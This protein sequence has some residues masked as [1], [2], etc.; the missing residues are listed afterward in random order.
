VSHTL[1]SVDDH[2]VEPPHLWTSRLPRRYLDVGPRVEEE[3]GKEFWVYED[4]RS[5]TVGLNAVVGKDPSEWNLDPLRFDD[6]LPGCYDPIARRRD[7][8][9]DGISGSMLFPSLPRFAGALFTEFEDRVLADLCVKSYNDFMIDEW[10]AAAPD[11]FI[12]LIICQLWDPQAAAMEV[13]RCAERGARAITFPE[14]PYPLGLPSLSTDFWDPLWDAVIE[15]D[16]AVCLH[17]GSSGIQHLPSPDAHFITVMMATPIMTSLNAMV[18]IMMGP[19]LRKYPGLRL[20]MSES[21]IGWVP[22]ALERLDRIWDMNRLW[23]D[24]GSARPSELF[25]QNFWV[26][27]VDEPF[28]VANRQIIGLDKIMWECDYP[29]AE[30]PWPHSR[31]AVARALEGVPDDEAALLTHGNAEAVFRWNV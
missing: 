8:E 15:T 13:R 21:G 16:I 27:F 4:K 5:D 23:V 11:M 6:M 1:I 3:D 31:E 22:N 10:C 20:V 9:A 26:C 7:L 30:T 12:P 29:H 25:A 2:L 14:N 17:I 19:L 28:G 24:V 18:D